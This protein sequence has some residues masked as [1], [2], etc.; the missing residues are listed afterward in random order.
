MDDAHCRIL[1]AGCSVSLAFRLSQPRRQRHPMDLTS[2][3]QALVLDT[4]LTACRLE[5][6]QL[7]LQTD[8]GDIGF[9]SLSLTAVVARVESDYD[10]QF[11]SDHI[12]GMFQTMLVI[13]LAQVIETAIIECRGG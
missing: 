7:T 2:S 9:D 13:D 4:L 10:V 6:S 12:L 11:S 5:P 3:V 1:T 8:L